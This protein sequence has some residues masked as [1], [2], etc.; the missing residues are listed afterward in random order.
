MCLNSCDTNVI[1]YQIHFDKFVLVFIPKYMNCKS[2]NTV[3]SAHK[4][5]LVT[6]VV[7]ACRFLIQEIMQYFHSAYLLI[8]Q[9]IYKISS[10]IGCSKLAARASALV[11][12]SLVVGAVRSSLT[13]RGL[14]AVV[15]DGGRQR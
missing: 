8:F 2:K 5:S 4:L 3:K 6:I 14:A 7:D 15:V 13:V 10:E 9:Q 1:I 11:W 12:W